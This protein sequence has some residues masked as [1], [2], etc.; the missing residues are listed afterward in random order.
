[1]EH[2]LLSRAIEYINR[3]RQKRRWQ[4]AV[5]AMAAVVVFCTTYALILPA[6]T[7]ENRVF[8]G[9]EAHLHDG[10][11]Y[12]QVLICE[13]PEAKAHTHTDGCYQTDSTL[14]C[15]LSESAG[16]THTD[17]CRATE[18][19][20]TCT[21]TE[22]GHQHG[23]G[24]YTTTT[25]VVCGLEESAGHTHG[26]ACWQ[27]TK[28]LICTQSTE[29]PEGGHIH[30]EACYGPSQ[31]PTCG[32]TE[33]E[34]EDACYVDLEADRE[35]AAQWERTFSDVELTGEFPADVLAIAETQLGYTESKDN[36]IK[37][38]EGRKLGYSRYGAWYG[39]PYGDWCAM[40]VSFC[41]HYAEVP[42]EAF[43][44]EANCQRW[45]LELS[46]RDLYRTAG[47]YT[48]EAGDLIF[49]N[50]DEQPDSDHV[51]LVKEVALDR[52]GEPVR[53]ETIEGNCSNQV[54]TRTYSLDD[55]SIM[56]YGELPEGEEETEEPLG[57][58]EPEGPVNPENGAIVE[59]EHSDDGFVSW[60]TLLEAVKEADISNGPVVYIF[61]RNK[62][63]VPAAI[64]EGEQRTRGV[65]MFAARETNVTDL[66]TYLNNHG[67]SYFY[68]L[69]DTNNEELPKDNAGNYIVTEGTT[70][71]L[72]LS[73]TSPDGFLPG[74]YQYQLPEGLT[75]DGGTGIFRINGEEVGTW[76]VA[77]DGLMML[78]FNQNMDS[79]TQVT[80]SAMMGAAFHGID[81]TIP[82]DGTIS[83]VVKP[84]PVLT[85]PT[86]LNK[87]G[88]QGDGSEDSP[89]PG[90]IYWTIE[91]IGG[92]DSQ[93]PGSTITDAFVTQNQS[94]TQSDLDGG[95]T[96]MA[97]QRDPA[98]GVEIGWHEWNVSFDDVTWNEDG[99][100]SYKIPEIV[101]TCRW[102]KDLHLGNEGWYY[103]VKYSVT[104]DR[105]NEVGSVAYENRVTFEGQ[106]VYGWSSMMHGQSTAEIVKEGVFRGDAENG[107]FVWDLNL[108]V[109][110]RQP[111]NKGDYFW[112]LWDSMKIKDDNDN[113]IY[114]HNDLDLAVVTATWNGQRYQVPK[115]EEATG[116][117]P[118]AWRNSWSSD[119][120]DGIYNGREIELLHRCD[121]TAESCPNWNEEGYSCNSVYWYV[122]PE[123][124]WG[125]SDYC[126]CWT[127]EG[128][129][130]FTFTYETDDP[131]ILAQYGG[132]GSTIRNAATLQN[133]VKG[134]D[135]NWTGN[136]MDSADA[137]V[138]IPGVFKKELTEEYDGHTAH[139]TITVNEAKLTLTEDGNTLTIVDT[140][141][142]TLAYISGSLVITTDDG[143]GVTETLVQDEDFTA[144]YDSDAHTLDIVLLNP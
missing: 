40:F 80:I 98:T 73:I 75:V 101:T 111:G 5:T 81:Q 13:L 7:L 52:A 37:N 18:T 26:E 36:Y 112:Y 57:P 8:C 60:E 120:N 119:H 30:G 106:S 92:K 46:Q 43:P 136:E 33:H 64:S 100:W 94:Y 23:D 114:V 67:G 58:E 115:V 138:E 85:D 68:T 20:L 118:F 78:V 47:T 17:A 131:E 105:T 48:P 133:K 45:I 10:D 35:T 89:D 127:V 139:Y 142:D 134:P 27:H 74:T 31:E 59:E 39:D 24:C 130:N 86:K 51:G 53:I 12:G 22:E 107:S 72:T 122:R 19:H 1:M 54:K 61:G 117:E 14:V 2:G 104:P 70:Y 79:K 87:W 25:E 63:E 90:K 11:C 144:V 135:G 55:R 99:S 97:S 141:T 143:N 95:L 113:E 3:Q 44:L 29:V 6:I 88:Y 28:T 121:C 126:H 124:G 4:K 21:S 132:T 129:T 83:V 137:R 69:T 41:L 91:L 76:T 16:H 77:D 103:W 128:E 66:K 49:F 84:P 9:Q 102:C 123:S 108:T 93:I 116:N 71:R 96:F 56:G 62:E 82:F 109:P 15:T 125:P 140:M 32:M 38:D 110:G 65:M 50:W 34:H 42:D